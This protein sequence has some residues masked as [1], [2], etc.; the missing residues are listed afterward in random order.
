MLGLFVRRDNPAFGFGKVGDWHLVSEGHPRAGGARVAIEDGGELQFGGNEALAQPFGFES[1]AWFVEFE[2][3]KDHEQAVEIDLLVI[4]NSEMLVAL[5]ALK[6]HA[7]EE[8]ANIPRQAGVIGLLL[9]DFVE[10]F[11]QEEGC[12]FFCFIVEIGAKDFAN[13]DVQRAVLGDGLGEEFHPVVV[14]SSAF[15]PLDIEGFGDAGGKSSICEETF[16]EAGAFCGGFV[17]EKC[18]CFLGG[19]D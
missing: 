12:A 13:E 15:H 16:D 18:A 10:S 6:I 1:L 7:E 8:S 5:G 17:G 11:G 9:A 4:I 3:L 2:V 14:F 19:W